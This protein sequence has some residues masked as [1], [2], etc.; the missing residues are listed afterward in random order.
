[1]LEK[2]ISLGLLMNIIIPGIYIGLRSKNVNLKS[3]VKL[4][5]FYF[6]MY[7][8]LGIIIKYFP[9]LIDPR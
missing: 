7:L 9:I 5:I 1:M 3:F 2:L 6:V 4:L 8:F